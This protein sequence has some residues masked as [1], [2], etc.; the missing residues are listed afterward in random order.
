MRSAWRYSFVF[1]LGWTVLTASAADV[2]VRGPESDALKNVRI[3]L[4]GL[5]S[6]GGELPDEARLVKTA[7]DALKPFGYY[8][9]TCTVTY[10]GEK[11]EM[12]VTPGR[13]IQLAESVVVIDGPAAEEPAVKKLL[14]GIPRAGSPLKHAD[15]EAFKSALNNLALSEGYFDAEFETSR[16]EVSVKKGEARWVIT[17]HSGERW[18]FGQT[19][20]EGSQIDED[21]LT[22]LVPYRNNEAFSA[23]RAAALSKNLSATGWFQSVAVTPEFSRAADRTLPMRAAVTPR[24]K[25]EVELGLGVDSDVGLNGEIQWAR[26]WINRRGHSLKFTSAV[27]ANEQTVSGQWK[28]PEKKDPVNSYWLVGSG[29]KHTDLNDTKSQSVTAT[30]SRTTLL[31]SGWQRTPS[32]TSSQTRFTQADVTK[33]TFLLYPGL[34]FSRIRQ[35]GGLSPNWGDSQRYTA[36]ISRRE[37]GSGTD[38]ALFRL[39]DSILRTWRDRHRF[40]GRITLGVI[41]ADDL[42]QVPPEKRFFA[43]G[44]KSIRGYGYQKISPR[45]DEGQLI[46]ASKL[47]TGTLEY[48]YRVT[49]GWWGAVFADAGDAVRSLSDFDVKKG[50]GFGVRWDS[51]VGP[52]KLDLAWPLGDKTESGV[53]FYVGLGTQW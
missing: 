11:A 13:Q 18:R 42:D 44:D 10:R 15:Y 40:V 53:H 45:D 22:S 39:Q 52:V 49:G 27:S 32:V 36:E 7:A 24:A 29:Y 26:P 51:P 35:R 31:A 9:A 38:F 48:Q 47:V 23:D 14:A 46:G 2:L 21:R 20:F 28:I 3:A 16:L 25:N 41:A 17:W 5:S 19:V 33:S 34:S 8:E 12:T 37:W 4:S 6:S 30:F 1:T 43:G 50:A